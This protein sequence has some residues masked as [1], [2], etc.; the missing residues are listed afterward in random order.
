M[1]KRY[2]L[3]GLYLA[4]SFALI[5]CGNNQE[6]VLTNLA[7]QIDL[8]GN[9][10]TSVSS[11][12]RYIPLKAENRGYY[13]S[14]KDI[15][16]QQDF[17]KTAILTKNSMIKQKIKERSLNLTN[18]NSKA[19]VDLTKDLSN[20]TKKLNETKGEF[21]SSIKEI[22][23]VCN[24]QNSTENQVSAKMNRLSN[25]IDVQSCFYKNLLNTLNNIEKILEIDDNSFD[26]S[27][28][29][30]ANNLSSTVKPDEDFSKDFQALFY[31]YMLNNQTNQN[32]SDEKNEDNCDD[33]EDKSSPEQTP[34]PSYV[35]NMFG[36]GIGQNPYFP[37]YMGVGYNPYYFNG[38]YPNGYSWGY[39]R[40]NFGKNTDSFYP[41]NKN[42]DTFRINPNQAIMANVNENEDKE[43][44]NEIKNEEKQEGLHKPPVKPLN[45]K[46][47][48]NPANK[49]DVNKNIEELISGKT[50]PTFQDNNYIKLG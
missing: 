7:N 1:K 14:A 42:I 21:T 20:N 47:D 27:Y 3:I 19:L 29:Y 23:S 9:T 32:H 36:S 12:D 6:A 31:Q 37:N 5:G 15:L 10:V 41:W 25:C 30:P 28:I 13:Q 38:M 40:F 34:P 44:K 2:F 45:H 24:N 26:Y 16:T 35:P 50:K 4:G 8:V 46:P 49:L 39:G 33:C 17:Y 48:F 43:T 22:K 18:Q 11:V